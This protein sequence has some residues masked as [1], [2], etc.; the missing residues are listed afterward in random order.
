ML[1]KKDVDPYPQLKTIDKLL[2]ELRKLMII[3]QKNIHHALEL[4]KQA[5]NQN[6]KPKRYGCNNKV[7]I[8]TKHFKTQYNR[9]LEVKFLEP[10]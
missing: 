8:N 7:L 3:C 4:Q 9:N 1:Y 10:F 5:Y 6:S 2:A